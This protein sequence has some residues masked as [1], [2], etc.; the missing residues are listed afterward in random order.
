MNGD[1]RF[2]RGTPED[3]EIG[4]AYCFLC[5]FLLRVWNAS[6]EQL[7]PEPR[8]PVLTSC[9]ERQETGVLK[10]LGRKMDGDE[11]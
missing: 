1:P 6:R 7:R 10:C 9:S 2:V 8:N 5:L 4:F 3:S 11:K